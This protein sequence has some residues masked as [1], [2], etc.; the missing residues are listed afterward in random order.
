MAPQQH[1][2]IY[3]LPIRMRHGE[4]SIRYRGIFINGEAP[5][6]TSFILEKFGPV[7]NVEFYEHVFELLLRMKVCSFPSLGII[8]GVKV[9]VLGLLLT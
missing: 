7:Y 8:L 6:L 5:S 2:E 4:P 1:K 9:L 3:A